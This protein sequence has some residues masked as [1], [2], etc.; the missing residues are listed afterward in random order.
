M[1][2]IFG[3]LNAEGTSVWKYGST[4]PVKVRIRDC[5]GSPVPGL[6][7]RVETR[8]VSAADPGAF[9]DGIGATT[10][11]DT[12]GVMRYDPTTGRYVYNFG[13][14]ALPDSAATYSLA[15]R[16]A[17]SQGILVAAPGV[18]QVEFGVTTK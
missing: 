4:F 2:E 1:S 8:L 14:T 7:P 10:A 5:H 3:P 17:D 12:T 13:S 11:A 18:V 16:G 15:V 9:I 6:A